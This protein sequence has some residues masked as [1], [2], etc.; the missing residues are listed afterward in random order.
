MVTEARDDAL[1]FLAAPAPATLDVE[2][3]ARAIVATGYQ[4]LRQPLSVADFAAAI[5]A[6]YERL[7]RLREEGTV[8]SEEEST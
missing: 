2:L 1:A 7:A 5:A 6:E 3:L 8:H 4:R